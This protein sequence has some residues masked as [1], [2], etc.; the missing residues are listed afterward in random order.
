[1]S[2]CRHTA[3][4]RSKAVNKKLSP[5]FCPFSSVSNDYI[6]NGFPFPRDEND[7]LQLC[8]YVYGLVQV[9]VCVD[10]VAVGW[11]EDSGC[12]EFNEA[13]LPSAPMDTMS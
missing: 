8:I 10:R 5:V 6:K 12:P 2:A 7:L 11:G 9:C 13:A 1:M 3:S 4:A